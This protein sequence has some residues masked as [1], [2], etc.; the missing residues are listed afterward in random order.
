MSDVASVRTDVTAEEWEGKFGT[1]VYST[2][3]RFAI[4]DTGAGFSYCVYVSMVHNNEP[5]THQPSV[6]QSSP[7]TIKA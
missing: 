4:I 1:K 3:R 5:S 7:T 2:V 6:D